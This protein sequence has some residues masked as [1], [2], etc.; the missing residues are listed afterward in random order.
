MSPRH[1]LSSGRFLN[2]LFV[3][4]MAAGAA[5]LLALGPSLAPGAPPVAASRAGSFGNVLSQVEPTTVPNAGSVTE[6]FLP[7]VAQQAEPQSAVSGEEAPLPLMTAHMRNRPR[8]VREWGV[9]SLQ[10]VCNRFRIQKAGV[11]EPP[12]GGGLRRWR[13]VAQEP[14]EA[15]SLDDGDAGFRQPGF[16]VSPLPLSAPSPRPAAAGSAQRR[17]AGR[18]AA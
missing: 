5:V 10:P 3:T 9:T 13:G 2:A 4:I 11:F 14:H 12:A 1:V 8:P 16:A 18:T 17:P 15:C 7:L 6:L